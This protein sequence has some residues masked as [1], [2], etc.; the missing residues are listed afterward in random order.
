MQADQTRTSN[1]SSEL[2]LNNCV[3]HHNHPAVTV[4][5]L[6][7]RNARTVFFVAFSIPS[8]TSS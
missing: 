2:P 7:D 3:L 5:R 6:D 1:R 4:V 8:G